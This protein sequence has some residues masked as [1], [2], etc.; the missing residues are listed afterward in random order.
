MPTYVMQCQMGHRFEQFLP[1]A[2]FDTL[3]RCDCG[4]VAEHV[5]T[6][7]L[8][9]AAQPECRYDSPVDGTPITSWAKRQDDLARNNCQPYD[10]AM[11]QDYLRRQAESDC[12]I[13]QAVGETVEEVIEKM[14]TQQRGKLYSELVEQGTD[15]SFNRATKEA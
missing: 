4:M 9:V 11:K 14:P 13:E 2:L 8:L 10:P 12:E 15:L 5:I 6:A 1:L 3:V 7:P